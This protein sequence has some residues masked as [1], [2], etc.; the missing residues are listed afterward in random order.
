MD[1]EEYLESI[2]QNLEEILVDS[3]F[4]NY[5]QQLIARKLSVEFNKTFQESYLWNRA[6]FLST[7]G[8][9]L[10]TDISKRRLALRCLKES[11]E[12][13]ENLSSTSEEYDKEYCLELLHLL[14]H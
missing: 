9:L 6:L 2:T 1:R 11:A 14:G 4:I 3:R 10:L 8:C 7:N 13:Y 5:K 12:I